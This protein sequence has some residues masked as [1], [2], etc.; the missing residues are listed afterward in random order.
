MNVP[1]IITVSRFFFIPL[2]WITFFSGSAY[3][4]LLA[5]IVLLL[6]GFSDMLD[7]Y[8]ARKTDQ[9][10]EMGKLLDPLA[11]KLMMI[12]VIL[13]FVI[14]GRITWLAA[15]IFFMRDAGMILASIF[16]H[17]RGKRK[18][19][20][21]NLMGKATTVLY[22]VVFLMIMFK[23]PYYV[24]VLWLVIIFS[25]ITSLVYLITYFRMDPQVKRA[26]Q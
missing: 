15:G 10:T 19:P 13:A 12:T 14:D 16:L 17:W 9:V 11:D 24:E 20:A 6:A 3:A 21:A 2:F 23:L 26:P 18:V 8:L 5:F 22:Y 4:N 25:L 1:N 7:G